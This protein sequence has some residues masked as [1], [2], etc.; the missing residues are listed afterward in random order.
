MTRWKRLGLVLAGYVLAFVG[1]GIVVA[2]YDRRF[3]AA[4]NQTMGGMI[5]GGEMMLGA[6]MF[7]FLSLFPTALALWFLRSNRAWWSWF[8]SACLVFAAVGLVA[9]LTQF[10]TRGAA[11]QAP[12]L[13]MMDLLSIAQMLGSPLWTAAFVLFAVLAPGRD[14]RRRMLAAVAIEVVIGGCGLVQFV[15]SRPSL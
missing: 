9:V 7:V 5:A 14:L 15:L 13:Q 2:I 4:D 12:I 10:A 6:G 1:S 8:T 3:S 11:P